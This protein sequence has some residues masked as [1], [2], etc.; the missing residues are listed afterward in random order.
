MFRLVLPIAALLSGVALMLLGLGLLNTLIAIRGGLE[1]YSDR[2]I[3][4]IM[5]GYFLGF[6]VG[7][8]IAS[9]LVRR[10]GHIRAFAFCAACLSCTALLHVLFVNPWIWFLLRVLAG[11]V[12]F[13]LYTI[14]ESWLN[15][16]APAGSRS[17][18]FALYMVVNL[19]AMAA[20]QQL[21]RLDSPMRFTLFAVAAIL[22]SL[23]LMPVTW[24]RL[25][26]PSVSEATSLKIGTLARAAPVAIAGA[27]L[28]GL[29]MGAF[30]GMAPVYATDIG[31]DKAGV[32]VFMSV[33][34]IGGAVLQFPIGRFSDN[35]DRR[36][37][38]AVVGLFA[39]VSGCA[40]LALGMLQAQVYAVFAAMFLYSGFAFAVYPVSVA[41][42][43]DHLQPQ[44]M[45]SGSSSLLMIYGFGAVIGPA[46]AGLLMSKIGTET[47][48]AYFAVMQLVLAVYAYQRG[49]PISRYEPQPASFVP[50]VRTTP[51]GLEM[52]PGGGEE[53][54]D[55]AQP[56]LTADKGQD[57]DPALIGE[58]GAQDTRP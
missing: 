4:V 7:T 2:L 43:V 41:H 19:M 30:W 25:V 36:Q 5:S 18:V 23:A 45:L 44:D 37:V 20:G 38:L 24:T 31:L 21:L 6:L 34:I 11:S 49:R 47:L 3:G 54:P 12:I 15:G 39:A 55:P 52:M 28:A 57:N 42:L 13:C 22:I 14:I 17:Q 35:H 32:A 46:V 40:V 50:M 1:G 9:R 33:A 51:T 8:H 53:A 56:N 58:N 10:I 16:Q 48:P 26:Q 27:L 29:T